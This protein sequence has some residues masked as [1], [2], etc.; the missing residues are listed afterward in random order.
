[1]NADDLIVRLDYDVEVAGNVSCAHY[2]SDYK[3]VSDIKLA[4]TRVVYL[5]NKDNTP[6][7]DS[8]V[9]VSI[10]FSEIEFS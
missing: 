3:E 7:T 1:M 8:P 6:D 2:L 10:D 5:K 4:T 9:V